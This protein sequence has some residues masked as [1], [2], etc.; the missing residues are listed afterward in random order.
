MTGRGETHKRSKLNGSL[1]GAGTEYTREVRRRSPETYWEGN[2][3]TRGKHRD[4]DLTGVGGNGVRTQ[5]LTQHVVPAWGDGLGCNEESLL[6]GVCLVQPS[7]AWDPLVFSA[8]L[9]CIPVGLAHQEEEYW[10]EFRA[11][12]VEFDFS[13]QEVDGGK[14]KRSGCNKPTRNVSC[15]FKA[16]ATSDGC[17]SVSLLWKL[18]RACSVFKLRIRTPTR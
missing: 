5:V 15:E 1:D 6:R 11:L 16:F 2:A 10:V 4:W 3:R 14:R 12:R 7:W 8:Y 13:T 18:I 9:R 17:R